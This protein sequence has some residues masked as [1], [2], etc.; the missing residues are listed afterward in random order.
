VQR[1]RFP[2]FHSPSPGRRPGQRWTAIGLSA[3]V[4]GWWLT[5]G[6]VVVILAPP[7]VASAPPGAF[8]PTVGQRAHAPGIGGRPLPIPVARVTFD[9][10][11][12]GFA[13]RDE[14]AIDGAF[15]S[16]EWIELAD[17]A[18]VRIVQIDGEAAEIEIPDGPFASYT[19]W[20]K[21]RH[22]GP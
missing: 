4:A 7:S 12:R 3:I 15:E 22:L 16:Y 14:D 2:W 10:A 8:R 11:Q 21:V 13:A 9:E 19:G 18:A 6:A 20:V 5:I 17:Q 1:H